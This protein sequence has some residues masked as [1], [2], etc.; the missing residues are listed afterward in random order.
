M[1]LGFLQSSFR[2]SQ[3]KWYRDTM[4]SR[5]RSHCLKLAFVYAEALDVSHSRSLDHPK[6]TN[7]RETPLVTLPNITNSMSVAE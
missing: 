1:Y 4:W 3:E 7:V 5:D 2:I 6:S